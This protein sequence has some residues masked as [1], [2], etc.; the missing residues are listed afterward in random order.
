MEID[1]DEIVPVPGYE[2]YYGA[3]RDGRV[4]SL[5]YRRTGKIAELAQSEL[6]DK[7]R[8][9]KTKYRRA[10]MYFIN[11][12]TQ[13]AVHRIV[14][15]TFVDNPHGYNC[16]NHI[17]G[18]KGDN[19][20]ENLEW[21]TN[22]QNIRHAEANNLSRHINGED[23]HAAILTEQRVREIKSELKEREYRGQLGDIAK[24]HNVS[25]HCIFDIKRGKSWRHV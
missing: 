12:N 14:A 25:I 20:A 8:M 5:N 13:T 15:L 24:K 19:R 18:D 4:F 21:C 3:T 6:T 16:V 9:S 10:K 11:K 2:K 7:R 1:Y 23:H 17:N 22:A